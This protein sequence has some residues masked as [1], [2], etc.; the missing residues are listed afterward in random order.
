MNFVEF[1]K[2]ISECIELSMGIC[3]NRPI[4]SIT[5]NDKATTNIE[6]IDP[7][8]DVRF[9]CSDPWD[10]IRSELRAGDC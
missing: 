8:W 2:R 9:V 10:Y 6:K 1:W 3:W 5:R 4:K 7:V